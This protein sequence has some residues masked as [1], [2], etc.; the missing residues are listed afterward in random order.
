M[1]NFLE[2]TQ[3]EKIGEGRFQANI[4][5]DWEV[6][7]PNGGY[8]SAI[9]FRAVGQHTNH[10]MPISFYGQYLSVAD[11]GEAIVEV[12]CIKPGRV[13]A[14]YTAKLIQNNRTV[15]QA[16]IW[17]ANTLEGLEH[18][19]FKKPSTYIP[20]AE[21]TERPRHGPMKFWDNLDIR[22]SAMGDGHYSHWYKL[23]PTLDICDAFADAARSVLLIDTMQWPATYHGNKSAP[24]YVAP[25]LDLSVRFH[26]TEAGTDWLFC[27]AIAD[28]GAAGIVSGSAS[29]WNENGNLVASGGSQSI[30]RPLKK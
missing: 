8:L 22:K 17:V 2:Q 28:I 19:Y 12:E 5:K 3:S 1:G 26:H 24:N 29:V 27:D 16:Q 14:A 9:V 13:A 6:W 11:F 15:L 10:T 20:L 25:S 30:C 23:T 7:G 21:A 18:Q 4:S